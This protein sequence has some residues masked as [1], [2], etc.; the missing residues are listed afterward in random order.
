MINPLQIYYPIEKNM[1][2]KAS[3]ITFQFLSHH[4]LTSYL[5]LFFI[6]SLCAKKKLSETLK[7]QNASVSK[8]DIVRVI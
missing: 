7:R 8:I 2:K 5:F 1:H 3:V 4:N 6:T